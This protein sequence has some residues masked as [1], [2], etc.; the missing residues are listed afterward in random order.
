MPY[1]GNEPGAITDALPRPSQV[2]DQQRI[3]RY[4]KYQPL[5][6]FLSGY[7]V[8]CNVMELILR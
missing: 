2:M 8:L 7:L 5:M 1:L 4:N 6:L 3:L